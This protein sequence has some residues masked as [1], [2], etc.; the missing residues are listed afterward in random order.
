VGWEEEK[1]LIDGH[2]RV[3]IGEE[4][5]F[6]LP[7]ILWLSFASRDDA[8][9]WMLQNQFA[10]RN[11]NKFQRIEAALHFKEFFA[12]Q[13]RVNQHGG[14]S[15]NSGKGLVVD[16]ELAKLADTSPDTVA[17]VVKILA[18]ADDPKVAK[19]INALRN[20][21]D[22]FSIHGVH[23][24]YCR[25]KKIVPP[26]EESDNEPKSEPQGNEKSDGTPEQ[27]GST[28]VLD[29]A[30]ED[31]SAKSSTPI[32]DQ[33]NGGALPDTNSEHPQSAT[34][35]SDGTDNEDVILPLPIGGNMK[36]EQSDEDS[37]VQATGCLQGIL[38]DIVRLDLRI[39]QESKMLTFEEREQVLWHM[40][41]LLQRHGKHL[42]TDREREDYRAKQASAIV[43]A[44]VDD[45][46]HDTNAPDQ[47][48]NTLTTQA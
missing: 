35:P 39:G 30:S 42:R 6:E 46:S 20:G 3:Q 9:M 17:K 40:R 23:E 32:P 22:G 7:P 24:R 1:R 44:S 16:D 12:E 11:L 28:S 36:S 18:K 31:T 10:R 25:R 45:A 29:Q 43:P 5:G 27:F 37:A 15:L 4:L 2:K 41:N 38:D 33:T 14:V 48:A 21:D 13:A 19:S 8:K 47:I 26:S 34:A